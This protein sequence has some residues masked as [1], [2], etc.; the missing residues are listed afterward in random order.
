MACQN[1]GN[2]KDDSEEYE[3]PADPSQVAS[4]E[5]EK[6]LEMA[7][8]GQNWK[9]QYCGSS[10]R[11]QLHGGCQ[12]CGAGRKEGANAQRP[13]AVPQP[14]MAAP[15]PR[16]FKF[17]VAHAVL[18]ALVG[19]ALVVVACVALRKNSRPTQEPLQT[20]TTPPLPPLPP[21]RSEFKGEVTA[22][23]WTRTIVIEKWQLAPHE[24]FT[25][26][27]P[28]G[29]VQ[30][31]AAGQ[32]VHHHEDVFD[33]D[34]TVYDDVTVP[35]GYKTETYSERVKCGE[36]CTT[37]PRT[38]RKVCTKTP[39]TCR[40]VCTNKKNG[41]ASCRD[42][43]TGGTESCR[44]DCSGGDR[45]CT[46]KYCNETKTKQTPK[47]RIEKRPRVVKKYRSEPRYAAWSTYKT[48]EWV[49][50]RSATQGADDGGAMMWPDA[51]TITPASKALAEAGDGGTPK[52][53]AEREQR[54]EKMNVTIQTDD[55]K[56]HD[57]IPTSEAELLRLSPGTKDLTVKVEGGK[58]TLL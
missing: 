3:M 34:E 40:Q 35:D 25:A 18:A 39:R 41:F 44:D 1:C 16:R 49:A 53:N 58:L 15:Q 4:V 36:D 57:Y 51:G 19:L 17:G 30:I 11:D 37:T 10:A 52:P 26:D 32:K 8:A 33:H 12:Q 56:S 54:E 29:G 27:V 28:E 47:T 14:A 22:A 45:K 24:A 20:L 31:V 23:S 6:L 43:C 46:P 9:C 42:D 5:D 21:P 55:G 50:I 13:Q 48:W 7:R 38:C 2:P